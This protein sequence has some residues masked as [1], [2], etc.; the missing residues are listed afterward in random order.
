[1]IAGNDSAY[2]N[3]GGLFYQ[4]VACRRL[5]GAVDNDECEGGGDYRV[6]R[7]IVSTV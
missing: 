6:I 7:F 1:M 4:K 5:K 2:M 3:G